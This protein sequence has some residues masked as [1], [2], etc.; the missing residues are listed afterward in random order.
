M[1]RVRSNRDKRLQGRAPEFLEQRDQTDDAIT[2]SP[3]AIATVKSFDD[4]ALQ[5]ILP[6]GI[7]YQT[8][9]LSV[10]TTPIRIPQNTKRV[11]M[12]LQN[13]DLLIDMFLTFNILV[14]SLNVGLKLV[15]GSVL[16]Y[17]INCPQNNINLFGTA[18]SNNILF[19]EGYKT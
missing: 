6:V 3:F 1:G 8:T 2:V 16:E 4:D 14:P 9:N 17:F 18:A 10:G 19:V 7:V 11:Y 15:P 5:K 13:N 12:M